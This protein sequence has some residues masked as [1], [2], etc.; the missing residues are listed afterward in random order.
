VEESFYRGKTVAPPLR[1]SL[2][3]GGHIQRREKKGG[4]EEQSVLWWG[5]VKTSEKTPINCA[6]RRAQGKCV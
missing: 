6:P 2:V 3:G 4:E 5:H 1:E